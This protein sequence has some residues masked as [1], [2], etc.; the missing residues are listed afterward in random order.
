MYVHNGK[1][2]PSKICHYCAYSIDELN[3]ICQSALESESTL[4]LTWTP[5]EKTGPKEIDNKTKSTDEETSPSERQTKRLQGVSMD[6]VIEPSGHLSVQRKSLARK[7]TAPSRLT[8]SKRGRQNPSW[9][10]NLI[11]S[12]KLMRL[13]IQKL[14]NTDINLMLTTPGSLDEPKRKRG[15]TRGPVNAKA[16]DS[17]AT[18]TK[19]K[20]S[21][22]AARSTQSKSPEIL[23][24]C[25]NCNA[26]L[27]NENVSCDCTLS[28]NKTKMRSLR[29]SS[30]EVVD[31]IKPSQ[32]MIELDHKNSTAALKA[33]QPHKIDNKKRKHDDLDSADNSPRKV[34]IIS[35]N[36]N[37][38]KVHKV[39]VKHLKKREKNQIQSFAY[40]VR[41]PKRRRSIVDYK[42]IGETLYSRNSEIKQSKAKSVSG[43]ATYQDV[44]NIQK[45]NKKL[46]LSSINKQNT[47]PAKPKLIKNLP[48]GKL[49]VSPHDESN[50]SEE[51]VSPKPKP[52][53]RTKPKLK[54]LPVDKSLDKL[55]SELLVD[56]PLAKTPIKS[57]SA[58]KLRVR[59]KPGRDLPAD[60]K[61]VKLNLKKDLSASKKRGK[62]KVSNVAKKKFSK[63]PYMLVPYSCEAC[64]TSF[65]STVE[66]RVHELSHSG[67]VGLPLIQLHRVKKNSLS[68]LSL[69]SVPIT[70]EITEENIKYKDE[71]STGVEESL[72]INEPLVSSDKGSH[73][74]SS[75]STKL[76]TCN[77]LEKTNTEKEISISD[78]KG[79]Q[80]MAV[81]V[82]LELSKLV[83]KVIS[84]D[85]AIAKKKSSSNGED[86]SEPK[87]DKTPDIPVA[88]SVADVEELISVSEIKVPNKNKDTLGHKVSSVESIE[89][90]KLE[91]VESKVPDTVG[92]TT[93]DMSKMSVP[94]SGVMS[95]DQL[96]SILTVDFDSPSSD[97]VSQE[98]VKDKVGEVTIEDVTGRSGFGSQ[99]VVL[100]GTI[101]TA[102]QQTARQAIKKYLEGWVGQV[103]DTTW[104][105]C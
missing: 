53:L 34:Q 56:K 82:E 55:S 66:G 4:Y 5:D 64:N 28:T 86:V 101:Q 37:L 29:Q 70:S 91:S 12:N 63:V 45:K 54:N 80:V 32:H 79:S 39:H 11:S 2:V 81:D 85:E 57:S 92:K 26:Q 94:E 51:L 59:S 19:A 90:N 36:S 13:S 72:N 20:R 16:R 96:L 61:Q 100:S 31:L 52:K 76:L 46:V 97:S 104:T 62:P 23:A 6:N 33:K 65:A 25:S 44:K 38:K 1:R 9:P 42:N 102:R 83:D 47:R 95:T 41:K 89:K 105:N 27:I 7:S 103:T 15:R 18:S 88:E 60:K 24:Y 50:I 78:E 84:K 30:V 43:K 21:G 87:M 14:E 35:L 17:F 75:D 99:S 8:T 67:N 73:L 93:A 49:S 69:S 10:K 40:N 98:S 71:S 3:D 74:L 77:G 68:E 48:L 22:L 58:N